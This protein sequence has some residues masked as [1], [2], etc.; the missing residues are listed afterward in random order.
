MLPTSYFTA[1][2]PGALYVE[3]YIGMYRALAAPWLSPWVLGSHSGVRPWRP[4][5]SRVPTEAP[6]VE[7]TRAATEAIPQRRSEG[8]LII[9][10]DPAR[11]RRTT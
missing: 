3:L 5:E 2:G 1:W 7:L 9:P 4:A 8:A 6:A 10:F 11:A